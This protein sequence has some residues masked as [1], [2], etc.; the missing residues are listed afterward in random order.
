M[1]DLYSYDSLASLADGDQVQTKRLGMDGH[2]TT[3]VST[4]RQM[5]QIQVI[6]AMADKT[7]FLSP[8]AT[9][10]SLLRH[11]S[12]RLVLM[13]QLFQK[14]KFLGKA[15]LGEFFSKAS[16]FGKT[17]GKAFTIFL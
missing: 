13:K 4:D 17:L 16:E 5:D 9:S 12:S 10:A 1:N 7:L 15:S 11:V 14:Y 3:R 8:S 2:N 6:D